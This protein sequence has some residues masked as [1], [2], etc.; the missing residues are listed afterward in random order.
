MEYSLDC[1]AEVKPRL[2]WA[3]LQLA[4]ICTLN[5]GALLYLLPVLFLDMSAYWSLPISYFLWAYS[6]LLL[7]EALISPWVGRTI[8]RI[9]A[10]CVMTYSSLLGAVLLTLLAWLPHPALALVVIPLLG[11]AKAGAVYEASFAYCFRRVQDAGKVILL[12]TLMAGFA[13]TVFIPLAHFIKEQWGWQ[14]CLLIFA[15]IGPGI[16]LCLAWALPLDQQATASRVQPAVI[17]SSSSSQHAASQA[18]QLCFICFSLVASAV[19]A[20][21]YSL[22]NELQMNENLLLMALM[23]IGPAQSLARLLFGILHQ[24]LGNKA[25]SIW[26]LATQPLAFLCLP[27]L[28]WHPAAILLFALA[29]GLAN[30]SMTMVRAISIADLFGREGYAARAGRFAA[31]SGIAAAIAPGLFASLYDVGLALEI[32]LLI[33]AVLA[34]LMWWQFVRSYA[35]AGVTQE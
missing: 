19:T 15:I 25:A 12:I 32:L 27:L 11:V 20:N 5:Y 28:W 29:F 23:L 3:T 9:G 34:L 6:G 7:V 26:V 8:E 13:S 21:M 30:G 24:R 18:L 1:C 4:L 2:N 17:A 31:P 33:G 10:R 14:L 16:S 22:L 35:L